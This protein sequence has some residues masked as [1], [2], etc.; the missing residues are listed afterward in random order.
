MT[1]PSPLEVWH[2]RF[3]RVIDERDDRDVPRGIRDPVIREWGHD[4]LA[5]L[6][7]SPHFMRTDRDGRRTWPA[8]TAARDDQ[9]TD[10]AVAEL[11]DRIGQHLGIGARPR[12]AVPEAFSHYGHRGADVDV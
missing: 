5:L 8:N 1:V 6:S 7:H 10:R 4:M 2:A 3:D 12:L 9:A 11:Y